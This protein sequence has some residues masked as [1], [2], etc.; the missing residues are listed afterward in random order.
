MDY[1]VQNYFI[2][3][4][5]QYLLS[6]FRHIQAISQTAPGTTRHRLRVSVAFGGQLRRPRQHRHGGN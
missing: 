2:P 5:W 4:D 6:L 3:Q 1:L